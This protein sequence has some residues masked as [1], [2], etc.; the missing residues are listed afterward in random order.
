MSI[1]DFILGLFTYT[2]VKNTPSRKSTPKY[3]HN[4]HPRENVDPGVHDLD[5]DEAGYDA[6][7]F[8]GHEDRFDD[9]D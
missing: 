7:C 5:L 6:D 3:S 4:N 8:E 1:L 9:Y 2:A